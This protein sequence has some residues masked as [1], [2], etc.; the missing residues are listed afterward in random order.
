MSVVMCFINFFYIISSLTNN[1][2]LLSLF[3]LLNFCFFLLVYYHFISYY[4]IK[5]NFFKIVWESWVWLLE[6][7]LKDED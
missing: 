5:F 7:V 3:F 1:L 6:N 4:S 2:L